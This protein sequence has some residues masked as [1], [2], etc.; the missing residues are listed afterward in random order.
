MFDEYTHSVRRVYL[1]NVHFILIFCWTK[2]WLNCNER[3]KSV[4]DVE[5]GCDEPPALTTRYTNKIATTTMNCER[6]TW[7]KCWQDMNLISYVES[8]FRSYMAGFIHHFIS[9]VDFS[10]ILSCYSTTKLLNGELFT[11][12]A[13][14]EKH[15]CLDGYKLILAEM[16]LRYIFFFCYAAFLSFVNMV[17]I[18]FSMNA[19]NSFFAYY[20]KLC[21]QP[22]PIW[23]LST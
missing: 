13:S 2:S 16:N 5:K 12:V 8:C 4:K 20:K 22:K 14:P 7:C 23:Q 19:G 21:I 3:E 9:L 10:C 15:T 11:L 6:Y 17:N 1:H 18:P